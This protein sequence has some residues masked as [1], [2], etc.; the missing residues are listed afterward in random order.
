[1]DRSRAGERPQT[2]GQNPRMVVRAATV[3]LVAGLA[4]ACATPTPAPEPA[5]RPPAETTPEPQLQPL[6]TSTPDTRPRPPMLRMLEASRFSLTVQD[7]DLPSVLLGLG[8]ESPLGVVVA[9]GVV[10][11]VT[12]DLK[13]VSLV[14]ILDEI[15]V[16]R[17]YHYAIQGRVLRIF[18]TDRETRTY[19]VDYPNHQRSGVSELS[20]AGFI[21][22]APTDGGEGSSSQG[23]EDLSLSSVTTSQTADLWAE[24]EGGI[25][26]LVFGSADAEVDEEPSGTSSNEEGSQSNPASRPARRVFVARQA[27]IV[28]VTAETTTLDQVERFLAEIHQSLERQVLIDAR[29]IEIT[30]DDELDLGVDI[31]GAPNLGTTVGVF[32]R[33]ITPGLREAAIAQSLAPVLNQGGIEF[34]IAR[35]DLGVVLRALALQTDVRVVSTPRIT[36][37]NNHKAMIKVVRN[38]IFF[39]AE[40]ETVITDT[41][42]Q[43]TTE[44]QPQVV[45]VGVTLDVTPH[46]SDRS[47]ITLHIRPSVSEIVA[48]E[49]QPTNDPNLPQN[50]SLPVVDL[51]ETDSVLRVADGTTI[52][53]GGLV[54]SREFEQVRRVP[55]LGDLPLLGSLFRGTRTEERRSEMVILLR[56]TVLDPPRIVR[57]AETF[58]ANLDALDEIRTDRSIG[59]PWWRQP[60]GRPLGADR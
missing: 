20:V 14:E 37:L 22:A 7:A 47:E 9:P 50:G 38:E 31:E 24:I 44:F 33:L 49:L 53:I 48:V 34:G 60:F 6:T 40:V 26:T 18:R 32:N 41:V 46:V 5:S 58:A 29:I 39:I 4:C 36:T 17:G 28:T 42:V 54:R 1:M 11:R 51:R 57:T 10:G 30:L 19:R 8:R 13:G 3:V 12:A 2:A 43:Q 27:G 55:L 56:P 25:R 45:P 23:G 59:F 21:G 35:N 52:V 16:A 15:V